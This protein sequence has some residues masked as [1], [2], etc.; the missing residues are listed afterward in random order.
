MKVNVVCDASP[1][2]Y[3]AKLNRLSLLSATLG[4]IAVPPAVIHETVNAGGRRHRPDAKRIQQALATLSLIPLELTPSEA[5]EAR[6]LHQM[7]P[8]G[9][10]ECEVI[11]CASHRQMKALLHD[12]KA[13]KIAA[14]DYKIETI[15]PTGVLFLALL[16][17][18]MTLQ[19]FKTTLRQLAVLTGLSTA[20]VLEQESI[21]DEIA[22]QLQIEE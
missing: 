3:F 13:Q 8:L 17:R 12:K 18:Q 15:S 20:T 6:Q 2:I 16:R 5:Q 21:A 7:F 19:D 10:G 11:A 22:R 4:P 1:L 9:L 14:E